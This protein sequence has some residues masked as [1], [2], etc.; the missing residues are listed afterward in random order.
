MNRCILLVRRSGGVDALAEDGKRVP[1][2]VPG[3]VAA[4]LLTSEHAGLAGRTAPARP[5]EPVQTSVCPV[6]G[7]CRAALSCLMKDNGASAVLHAL[8][9]RPPLATVVSEAAA[10]RTMLRRCLCRRGLETFRGVL[11]FDV[12]LKIFTCSRLFSSS[13]VDDHDSRLFS[14]R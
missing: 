13:S 14:H 3:G 10:V 1:T 4:L 11:C 5:C 12:K 9:R 6:D 7:G 2:Q 8:P